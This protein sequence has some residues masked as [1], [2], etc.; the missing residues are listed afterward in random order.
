MKSKKRAALYCPVCSSEGQRQPVLSP[1]GVLFVQNGRGTSV[2][3]VDAPH[4]TYVCPRCGF[5]EI[6]DRIVEAA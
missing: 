3:P 1:M 5:G 4:F 2:E 6:H